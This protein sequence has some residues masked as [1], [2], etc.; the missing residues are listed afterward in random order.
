MQAPADLGLHP[1]APRSVSRQVQFQRRSSRSSALVDSVLCRGCLSC[2][3]GRAGGEHGWLERASSLSLAFCS[4]CWCGDGGWLVQLQ[5]KSVPRS[6]VRARR[7]ACITTGS[8][9]RGSSTTT[10]SRAML[11]L[12]SHP[13][14]A[15]AG[16]SFWA[17]ALPSRGV[18]RLWVPPLGVLR[19][20]RRYSRRRWRLGGGSRWFLPFLETSRS[21]SSGA[22]STASW[23]R[24]CLAP[25]FC[26]RSSS[27]QTTSARVICPTRPTPAS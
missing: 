14:P 18:A 17:I 2:R 8:W 5:R 21:T 19:A 22:W 6:Q 13:P 7:G 20:C 3:A 25:G 1:P 23:P 26:L 27:A 15:S 24:R 12:S 11:P 4:C 9:T 10:L 16:L